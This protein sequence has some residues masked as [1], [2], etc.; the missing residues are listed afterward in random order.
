MSIPYFGHQTSRFRSI[1][2]TLTVRRVFN[3]LVCKYA[4]AD[5]AGIPVKSIWP[6]KRGAPGAS[7]GWGAMHSV[8]HWRTCGKLTFMMHTPKCRR[9]QSKPCNDF[10]WI[11]QKI[12][13][14]VS[15]PF[16]A[17]L[18]SKR[19]GN[20]LTSATYLRGT[21][22][23]YPC[24]PRNPHDVARKTLASTTS[25]EREAD[26]SEGTT[27]RWTALFQAMVW[28]GLAWR[29]CAPWLNPLSLSNARLM[30]FPSATQD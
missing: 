13:E 19:A 12:H 10:V 23:R 2:S 15:P 9:S 7:I 1:I 6:V 25:V 28:Y 21:R 4:A 3:W 18:P 26:P 20:V 22:P 16:S 24:S 14:L 30:H 29:G 11:Q 5:P 27:F 8:R 17:V